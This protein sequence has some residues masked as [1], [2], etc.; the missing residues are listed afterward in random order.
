MNTP[1]RISLCLALVAVLM[2]PC[3]LLAQGAGSTQ[4]PA[5]APAAASEPEGSLPDLRTAN[6][7]DFGFRG[8]SFAAGSDE[9]RAQRFR[10]LR[11]GPSVDAFRYSSQTDSWLFTARAEHVGYR[12]QRYWAAYN[13]FGR[14]KASF[15]WNQIPLFYSQE[16][17]TLFTTA[18]PGVLRIDDGIQGG[19]EGKTATPL[20]VIG[21]AQRFDLRDRRDVLALALTYSATPRLDWLLSVK[22]TS[23]TGTQPWA[24]TFGFSDAVDLPVPLDTRTTELGTALEWANSRGMA[25]VGYDG[26]FFR[27]AVSTLTWDNPLRLTDSPTAGPSQGREALWPNS[28]MNAVNTTGLLNLPGHSRASAYLSVGSWSQNAALVPF[29]IN[30][31]LPAIPLDRANADALARVTAM[32]YA[33]TSKPAGS[34]WL[35]ARYRSY[36]FDNRTPIFHVTNTVSY[37]TAVAAFAEGGTSPYSLTRRTFDADASFTP[38]RY[39]ALR[40]GFTHEQVDQT[41]RSFDTTKENTVRLSADA[42]DIAWLTLRAVYEHG[43]RTGSGLDEQVLDDI[44]EQISLRQFDI[45]DRNS[46]RFSAIIQAIPLS[47][48]SFSGTAAVGKEDRSGA[49]FGLRSNNNHAYSLGVDYV[50]RDA[51]SLGLSYQY[52]KYDSGQ[53]S[54]QA[55]PGAQFADP[56]RDWTTDGADKAQTLAA[57]M[58][59]LKVWPKVD[60]RFALNRSHAE[61]LYVYG[62]TPDTTLPPVVQLP[63]VVNTFLRSTFDVR[64]YVTRHLAAGGSYWYDKYSVNDFA[65]GTQ[66]VTTLA[67]PSFVMIGYLYRPYTANVVTGRLTYIW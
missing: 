32:T 29:T 21:Q 13:N 31:A 45:S 26:S 34:L 46:D 14:L 66:T 61:S 16:T 27:N 53:R 55:N 33:F 64:Y 60:L 20:T 44:G 24:G 41:Q 11:N 54:R 39:T 3:A 38:M 15:E 6:F 8:T 50:P 35:S 30:T 49:V 9:G 52:E 43:K 57:S 51:M 19:I 17:A 18:S 5:A 47:A 58:D 7:I 23:K 67:Q 62:L 25:R 4:Q 36:D 40:A 28:S 37:D 42:T 56:T 59:L 2:N 10:D 63:T 48:L 12:D 1:M 22:S 65:L